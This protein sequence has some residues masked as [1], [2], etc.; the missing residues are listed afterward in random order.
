[1]VQSGQSVKFIVYVQLQARLRNVGTVQLFAPQSFFMLWLGTNSSF[2]FIITF[3]AFT[4]ELGIV[5]NSDKSTN[6][7]LHMLFIE[8][9]KD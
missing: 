1:M 6:C 2:I 9:L 3:I 5:P 4:V 7:P 8:E